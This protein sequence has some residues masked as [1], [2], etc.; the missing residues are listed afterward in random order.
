[1]ELTQD[2]ALAKQAFCLLNHL[3]FI[4]LWLFWS[5][6]GGVLRT[7]CPDWPGTVI[8]P[9][10]ASQIESISSA[11]GWWGERKETLLGLDPAPTLA[12][13]LLTPHPTHWKDHIWP[14]GND[15]P[16]TRQKVRSW[17]TYLRNYQASPLA[18]PSDGWLHSAFSHPAGSPLQTALCIYC[19]SAG[20]PPPLRRAPSPTINP[21]LAF[22]LSLCRFHV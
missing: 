8:L 19:R 21:E 2:F 10:S 13:S 3:Q 5:G 22:E 1:L 12:G 17:A 20:E 16:P 14:H 11:G 6:G 9:I 4:F 15:K 18:S 7:S